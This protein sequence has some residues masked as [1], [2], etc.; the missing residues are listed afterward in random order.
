MPL[1]PGWAEE[2][3]PM[4]VGTE[5][6]A[7]G[8]FAVATKAPA[9]PDNWKKKLGIS[10]EKA[11][12]TH[13]L[14]LTADM[15]GKTTALF[16]ELPLPADSGIDA[17]KV[18]VRYRTK[19]LE[20]SAKPGNDARVT[21]RFFDNVR[22]AFSEEPAPLG[23][24]AHDDWT[25]ASTT[26]KIPEHAVSLEFFAGLFAVKAGSLDLAEIS[27][28]TAP[29]TAASD[30]AAAIPPEAQVDAQVPVVREGAH[31]IIG[32]GK[33]TVWFIHPYV[34]VLGHDFVQGITHLVE[35]A[36]D[37]G[38]P[39]AVGVAQGLDATNQRDAANT[40]YVFTY[41]N[42]DYPLPA[43]ARR[44]VFINTW[45]TKPVEWPAARAVKKDIV[46]IGSRTL[47]NDGD[48]LA[49]DKARWMQIQKD[50]PALSLTVLDN[51][52]YYLPIHTWREPIL[53]VIMEE[54]SK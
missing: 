2:A 15:A 1:A 27:I 46:L 18:T 39:V 17:L 43:G 45:L 32:Y 50:D 29:A 28:K 24:P 13:Y 35:A 52:G 23:L 36:R 6:L 19:D 33:P 22:I 14:H 40:I 3:A 30:L 9:W 51:T 20:A 38:N 37:E 25:V 4:P 49:T 42:I 31:T 7:N 53:K 26:F 47:G 41:K 5:L 12:S 48:G 10:W 44:L 11:D 34:D 8:D 16:Q 21:F 54:K